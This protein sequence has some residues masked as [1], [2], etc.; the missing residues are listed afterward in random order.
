MRCAECTQNFGKARQE[1]IFRHTQPDCPTRRI[2]PEAGQDRVFALEKM[3]RQTDQGHAILG[4]AHAFGASG[5]KA[6]AK[7]F[8]QP[9]DMLADGGLAYPLAL[10][11]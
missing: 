4:Q 1:Q 5:Q 2:L 3:P 8:L 11:G 10:R 9:A 6:R 7:L